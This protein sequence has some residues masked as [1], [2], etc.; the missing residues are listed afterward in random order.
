MG[1][2]RSLFSSATAF[3][4]KVKTTVENV[5]INAAAD[6]RKSKLGKNLEAFVKKAGQTLSQGATAAKHA[7]HEAYRSSKTV[8]EEEQEYQ[9]KRARDGRLKEADQER[10]WELQREREQLKQEISDLKAGMAALKLQ[11]ES[12]ISTLLT[13]DELSANT[14]VL[15]SKVCPE[16]G[17]V[18]RIRQGALDVS[19]KQHRFWWEC[20]SN[21][22]GY[23]CRTQKLDPRSEAVEVIRTANPDLDGDAANRRLFWQRPTVIENTYSRVRALLGELDHD[24]MCPFHVLPMQLAEVPKPGGHLL[25]SY[26]YVCSSLQSPKTVC[27]YTIPITSFPQV[28]A[29][30]RRHTDRGIIDD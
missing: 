15:A 2:L 17:G 20:I 8:F 9:A 1:F 7:V 27:G 21:R 16:C 18:M 6:F 13:A 30:L 11:T 5:V 4:D 26:H 24:L 10:L 29:L 12:V 14:G 23:R 3:V 28:S 25:D 22:N 19:T